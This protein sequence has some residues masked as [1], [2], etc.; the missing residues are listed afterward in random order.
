MPTRQIGWASAGAIVV[1]NMI[2]TG[3]FTTLGI[4]AQHLQSPW[5]I[6]S[7]WVLG[8][9]LSL[10]G[11]FSYA[12]L[13]IRMPRSGGEFHFLSHTFHPLIGYLSGWIS[14][15]VG[16]TASIALAAVA[17]GYYLA[18][19]T[20]IPATWSALGVVVLVSGIHSFHLQQSSRFQ[21]LVTL[22]KIALIALLVVACFV[23]SPARQYWP[24]N[25]RWLAEL[26]SFHYA[27]A[28]VYVMYAYSGWNAA[29]YIV[30]E[31]KN[32]VRNLPRALIGGAGTVS[33]LYVLLQAG[34]LRQADIA[35]L[36]GKVEVAEIVAVKLFGLAGGQ[37][38]GALVGLLLVSCVSAM[39]WVGPRVGRS[40]AEDY[41]VWRFLA[42]DN[43]HGIPVNAIWFQAAIS[44]FMLCSGSFE[45]VLLY[46]GFVLHLSTMATVAGLF[47]HRYRERKRGL[48]PLGFW[49]FYPYGQIIFL[50]ISLWM[51][52]FMLYDQP[53]ESLAGFLNIAVG[54]ISY[55]Y[56]KRMIR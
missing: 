14:L 50:L 9:A 27:V 35:E 24:M 45:Q 37:W 22:L 11:A 39:I 30:G 31:L 2:G 48:K 12:E 52:A 49:S 6:L 19:I 33:L 44:I 34:F 25:G 43:R 28:L 20:G 46:S 36:A 4:Q 15:T 56:N 40:M 23:V 5:S 21:N 53:F 29:A 51:L 54:A 41:P 38:I 8:G 16:F 10:L 32:P 47:V 18:S 55:W 26:K 1:A 42:K 3:A 17:M 7:L 13:G